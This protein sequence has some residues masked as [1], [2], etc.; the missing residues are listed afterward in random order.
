MVGTALATLRLVSDA[1]GHLHTVLSQ[2]TVLRFRRQ[3][4]ATSGATARAG[5]RTN[6]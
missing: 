5:P 2:S 3:Y 1:F 4:L 6:V